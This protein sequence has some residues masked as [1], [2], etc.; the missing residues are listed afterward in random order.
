[1]RRLVFGLF[2]V[3]SLAAETGLHAS[4]PVGRWRTQ[5]QGAIVEIKTCAELAPCAYLQW[6]D[7]K[8]S[9][10]NT[11]DVRNPNA[12]QQS[13]PLIGLPIV[14][15]MRPAKKGWDGGRVYNPETGQTFRSSMQSL[16][17]SRLKVTGCWG[18][19]CRSEIW[20]RLDTP[21]KGSI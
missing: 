6:V 5:M 11:K 10:S 12:A 20:V 3:A 4:I 14:W 15:G 2:F 18:L 9:R 13:R 17:D 16:S 1:M 19:L 7:P 8:I 21:K